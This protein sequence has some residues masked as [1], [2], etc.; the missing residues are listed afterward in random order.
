MSSDTSWILLW[1]LVGNN[2]QASAQLS[3]I[4]HIQCCQAMQ[5]L[6]HE[7]G[8]FEINSV[9]DRQPCYVMWLMHCRSSV[10]CQVV[11]IYCCKQCATLLY[12]SAVLITEHLTE[13]LQWTT[14]KLSLHVYK[15]ALICSIM[16]F[17]S[18]LLLIKLVLLMTT[19]C[20]CHRMLLWLSGI[21]KQPSAMLRD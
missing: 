2:C 9:L 13:F 20:W 10:G 5:C 1:P 15:F 18:S 7:C 12:S 19:N 4:Q 11:G 8:S 16:S 14:W 21:L 17:W 6:E 3:F